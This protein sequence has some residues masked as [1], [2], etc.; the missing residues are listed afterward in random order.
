M[1]NLNLRK[2]FML[3]FL[4][5]GIVP[6][7]IVSILLYNN[8][9]NEIEDKIYNSMK[10]YGS[11]TD[12][13][14]EKYFSKKEGDIRVFAR[15]SKVYQSL[16]ILKEIDKSIE[17]SRWQERID[18]LDKLVPHFVKEYG[19]AC[20]YITDTEGKVVYSTTDNI[21][22]GTD[23]ASRD[24]IKES[25]KGDLNWSELFY[26]DVI[27][28]NALV[29]S[30]PVKSKGNKGEI[31]G[32]ANL[33]LDQSGIDHIVHDGL[34]KLGKSAD[35]YLIN[36]E[37]LLLTNTL[38]GKYQENAALEKKIN[39]K[40]VKLLSAPINNKDYS[41][42]VTDQYP[43]YRDVPVLGELSVTKIGNTPVGLIIEIDQEEVFS[44]TTKLR[45]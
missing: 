16:N 36:S 40:A 14:L 13:E 2:K 17:S 9:N 27:N 15:T 10:M 26:S 45:N 32:T 21:P 41:F 7:L 31:T 3:L 6:L 38:L 11:I 22:L 33:L 25:L 39:T 1:F 37:G 42:N 19:F 44:G 12:N 28:K 18:S 4:L 43:E 24:Y 8:A 35:A 34:D 29:V 20:G 30:I 5:V 23:I